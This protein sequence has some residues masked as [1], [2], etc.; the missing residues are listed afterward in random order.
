MT[1]GS[2]VTFLVVGLGNPGTA[3]QHHRHN[4]GFMALDVIQS[5]YHFPDFKKDKDAL[6]TSSRTCL[7]GATVILMKPQSFMNRSGV[8]V[9]R[10]ARFYKIAPENVIVLHDELDLPLGRVKA[11][12]G[13]GAGGHNGLRSLDQHF[14]NAT[15]RIR[16]GI[17]HPGHKDLVTAHVLGNFTPD[18]RASV[19]RM[20]DTVSQAF[21]PLITEGLDAFRQALHT[22]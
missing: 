3:Y 2:A 21:R 22:A 20:L 1:I 4:V 9:A 15:T 18:E 12:I 10:V 8:P 5:A 16:L 19:S 14:G 13:G 11:K 17:S 6:V 7:P